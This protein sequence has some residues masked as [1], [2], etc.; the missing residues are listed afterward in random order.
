MVAAMAKPFRGLLAAALTALALSG[1]G[2]WFGKKEDPPLPGQRLSVMAHSRQLGPDPAVQNQ[3]ILLPRPVTN[4]EWPQAG[5]YANHAMHHLHIGDSP[6]LLWRADIGAATSA[7]QPLLPSPIVVGDHVFAMDAEQN[8]V[9]FAA[10]SGDRIWQ[11]EIAPEEEEDLIPGGIAYEAGT[12]FVST[13]F[14]EVL[15]LDA[16]T[17]AERWRRRV[18]A[19]VHAPPT[20]RDGQVYAITITNVLYALNAADGSEAWTFRAIGE[21][22]TLIG[23]ASPAVDSGIVV[24]PF[25]SGEVVALTADNGQVLWTESFASGR[26]SDEMANLAQIRGAPVIDRGRVFV[27]SFAGVTAAI[28]LRTGR[29]LWDQEVGGIERPWVAGGY[30]YLVSKAGELV[31]LNRDTGQIHWITQL[32]AYEDEKDL[33]DPILWSGPVL[34]ADRL[35]VTGTNDQ[36]LTL[37]PYTGE[38]LGRLDLPARLIVAPLVANGA[39]YLLSDTATLYAYR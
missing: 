20:V 5:G 32:P 1:C 11:T 39:I 23:G 10:G 21:G 24:A 34:A 12:I 29:R 4:S 26:R 8:V 36:V 31:C 33:E 30:V 25:S 17:G 35:V 3:P 18:E 14:A 13:G 2:T 27:V 15:A 28:D 22:A 38:F 19:P 7:A 16:A 6:R 37:S 9:A